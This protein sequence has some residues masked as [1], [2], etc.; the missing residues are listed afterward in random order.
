MDNRTNK[1]SENINNT[2]IHNLIK[3]LAEFL[4][5]KGF[6]ITITIFVFMNFMS[7]PI[8]SYNKNTDEFTVAYTSRAI[9]LHARPQMIVRY[10]NTVVLLT[11]IIGYY[12]SENVYFKDNK[13]TLTKTNEKYAERLKSYVRTSVLEKLKKDY[14]DESIAEIDGQ[15]YIYISMICGVQYQTRFG[16]MQNQYCIIENDGM[17]VDCL[18]DSNKVSDRL[19]DYEITLDDNTDSISTNIEVNKMIV[20]VTKE[21]RHLY[22]NRL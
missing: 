1:K 20:T 7:M 11:H 5:P 16:N 8:M 21:V 9:S 13:A 17:L 4:I 14:S 12:E 6:V 22:D 15:L 3:D 10:G 19:N 18:L 2:Q